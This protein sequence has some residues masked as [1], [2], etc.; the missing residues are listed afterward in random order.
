MITT[1][2]TIYSRIVLT[3]TYIS[4]IFHLARTHQHLSYLH[5]TNRSRRAEAFTMEG[6][7]YGYIPVVLKIDQHTEKLRLWTPGA[8][9]VVS[10]CF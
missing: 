1:T 7:A 5:T 9:R 2:T 3:S 4:N 8:A 10:S 6:K